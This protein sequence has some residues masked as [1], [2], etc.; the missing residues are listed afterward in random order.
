MDT[1]KKVF[2][3]GNV[4]RHFFFWLCPFYNLKSSAGL[5]SSINKIGLLNNPLKSSS[6]GAHPH[7]HP[8]L[9]PH[10]PGWIIYRLYFIGSFQVTVYTELNTND[11]YKSVATVVPGILAKK[12]NSTLI[13]SICMQSNLAKIMDYFETYV[14]WCEA[15]IFSKFLS[16]IFSI[17]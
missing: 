9:H 7:L 17:A 12:K 13:V 6:L 4:P 10:T 5:N 16:N 15:T 8:H 11:Q 2:F 1:Q 3:L 14:S